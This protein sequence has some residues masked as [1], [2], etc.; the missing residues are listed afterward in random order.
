MPSDVFSDAPKPLLARLAFE[1]DVPASE[2]EPPA[3]LVR[4]RCATIAGNYGSRNVKQL[5]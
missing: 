2:K 5:D 1:H 4:T 3:T